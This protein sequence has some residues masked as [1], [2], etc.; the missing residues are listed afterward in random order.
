MMATG[1]YFWLDATSIVLLSLA[2]SN[3]GF[4]SRV[5]VAWLGAGG[6]LRFSA[7]FGAWR[8]LVS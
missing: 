6:R 8:G 2:F 7:D 4:E 1:C 3:F 5:K